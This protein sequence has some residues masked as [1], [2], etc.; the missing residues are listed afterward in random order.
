MRTQAMPYIKQSRREAINPKLDAL[1]QQ[2]RELDH[3][4]ITELDGDLNYAIS[5]LLLGVFDLTDN[6]KYTK[7]NSALGVLEGVKL[8]MYRRFTAPYEDE[9]IEENGDIV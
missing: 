6:P 7:F 4:H 8:E 2:I 3:T 1:I 5:N 9:K